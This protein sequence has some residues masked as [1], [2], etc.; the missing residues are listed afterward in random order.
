MIQRFYSLLFIPALILL[1][2]G[3]QKDFL[4]A[5][6][7]KGL[8]IPTTLADFRT[9][10]DNLLVFNKSPGLTGIADGDLI[11]TE[12]GLKTYSLDQE[13]NSYIW[14]Q[15]IYGTQSASEWNEGFAQIFYANVV[16]DG[17][18][19]LSE[20]TAEY[21]A[22]KGTAL[23]HRA[24]VYYGLTQLYCP[25]YLE[26]TASSSL[27]LPIRTRAA[28]TDVVSRNA[29]SQ[30]YDQIISDL[31]QARFLLPAVTAY[32]SRPALPAVYALL[33]RIYLIRGEYD[34]AEAYADS[35]L[36]LRPGLLDYNSL[37][38]SASRPMPRALPNGNEEVLFYST[39]ASY[40]FTGSTAVAYIDP[41]LYQSY[42]AND[43]R[44]TSLF[45]DG[46]A[47]KINFKGTY[48]GVI[49]WF[50]GLATDEVYLTRAECLARAGK[51]AAAM[52]DL[53]TLLVKRWK[54]GTY[55]PLNV[56]GQDA[57]L[58]LVLTERRKELVGR[59]MRW[60]DLKRLNAVGGQQISLTRTING[61]TY[62]LAPNDKR[63]VYPI[64][65]EEVRLSGLQ[66]N[67]R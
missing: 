45:R 39:G 12:V 24:W 59:N 60:T 34:N 7:D 11:T 65:A 13:R 63:Y 19:Q 48:T 51:T 26:S 21:K 44:K 5:K 56:A 49:P 31:R 41:T 30:T 61:T 3:C 64:P 28:V 23:F 62:V 33:S 52:A 38:A 16:L 40:T 67:E 47:G 9:L 46:G 58:A 35:V 27:G 1:L 20:R 55:V 25:V 4:E 53:N 8:L 22:V 54:A 32:K 29:L 36:Q 50:S 6:P 66:Q 42:A 37:V 57:A 15:D 10:L 17:L 14:A 43:L 18:G 2:V